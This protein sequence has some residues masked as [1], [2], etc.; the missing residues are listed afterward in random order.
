M[1][2]ISIRGKIPDE[3]TK[4]LKSGIWA[5]TLVGKFDAKYDEAQIP[6]AGLLKELRTIKRV[7]TT[8][9]R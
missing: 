3:F 6:T 2:G 8:A 7:P 1:D 4:D 9:G 5:V